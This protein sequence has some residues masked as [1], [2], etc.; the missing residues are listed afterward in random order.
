MEM[1]DIINARV[2]FRNSP[3]HILEKFTF[4]DI[5]SAYE[6][7]RN[8][9]GLKELVILQTCN[10]VE[11]FGS[12]N[13]LD[14]SKIKKTWASLAGLE[15][16]AFDNNFEIVD[17]TAVCEH[18]LRLTTGLDSM[19]V[20]EE[21]ILGQIRDAVGIAKEM[22]MSGEYL[23]TL[24]DK[25]VKIGTRVRNSTG[26]NK[27]TISVGSMAVKLAEEN[28]DDLKSKKILLIGTGEAATLV[29]KSLQK[30]GYSFYVTS[31][32]MERSQAFAETV[33]GKPINFE[34]I[35]RAFSNYDVLF[36]ATVAPYFLVTFDRIKEAM[37]RKSGMMILDL[38]NPRTVDEKVATI[39]G[40]K[41]MNLDQIAEM[42][43]KNMRYRSNQKNNAEKIISEEIQ[44]LEAQ[45]RRLEVEPVVKEIFKDIDTRR[46]KELEKALRMLGETD[47]S[48]VKI[49]DD[50]TKAVVEGIIST[51]MNNLRKASEQA[52]ADLLKA[53][54]K[55]FDYKNKD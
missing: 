51:P 52:D 3:I 4:K 10:R 37:E 19:V 38:S 11:I 44:V 33:G 48:K 25:A 28:I 27:G 31:R 34:E 8:H 41:M 21:Q 40:I 20:G 13:N 1:S 12:T 39:R 29:A 35:I 47:A 9:S 18:L 42:V 26:I 6:S 14:V 23:N 30:R 55:L 32:T 54:S 53:A 5:D 22:K 2:T 17:D 24:F 50:L 43:D 45:M 7:F 16:V 36:V 15:E 49:I 46:T